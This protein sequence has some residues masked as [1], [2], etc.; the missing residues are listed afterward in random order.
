[1][2]RGSA[3][4]ESLRVGPAAAAAARTDILSDRTKSVLGMW[5]ASATAAAVTPAGAA[6]LCT[7][8]SQGEGGRSGTPWAHMSITG[9]DPLPS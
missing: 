2:G 8:D 4:A 1:L 9:A 6:A 7:P 5:P 3:R